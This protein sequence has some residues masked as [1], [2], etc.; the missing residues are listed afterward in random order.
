MVTLGF[1]V[2]APLCPPP[3]TSVTQPEEKQSQ[4]ETDAT[5]SVVSAAVSL[6]FPESVQTLLMGLRS[7][8]RE[9]KRG[10]G[11]EGCGAFNSD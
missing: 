3:S 6:R 1:E 11:E 9:E 4:E 8:I 7:R 5:L 10:G 2:V